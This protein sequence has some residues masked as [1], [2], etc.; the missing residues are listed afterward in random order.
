MISVVRSGAAAASM[1]F[2]VMSTSMAD[3]A[4]RSSQSA[5]ELPKEML[6]TGC[7]AIGWN[8]SIHVYFRPSLVGREH[9]DDFHD[10]ITISQDG[11]SDNHPAVPCPSDYVFDKVEQIKDGVYLVF[12][13]CQEKV[14]PEFDL[15]GMQQL[16]IVDDGLLVIKR[17]PEG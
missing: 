16:Q 12:A 15:G 11:F 6:G 14:D 9:C 1:L 5:I 4:N 3:P 2:A 13:R 7:R 10:G 8:N 17:M